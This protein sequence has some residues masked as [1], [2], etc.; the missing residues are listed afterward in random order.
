VKSL[1]ISIKELVSRY[2]HVNWALADQAMVSGVN[3]LTGIF[4]A[5]YLG[6]EEYGYFTLAWMVVQFCNSFQHAGIIAP[7]M[8]LGP[9]QK[10]EVS[11]KFYGA[12][13]FQQLVW[14]TICAILIVCVGALCGLIAPDLHVRILSIPL[15]GVLFL[16]Q[17][18]DF[19]R[20]YFFAINKGYLAFFNDSISYIGQIIVLA[21]VGFWVDIDAYNG[22]LIIGVTSLIAVIIGTFSLNVE[23]VRFSY[24]AESVVENHKY[25]RWLIYS[26]FMQYM[27]ANFFYMVSGALLGATSVGVIK[28]S[29]NIV[30]ILN[31]L[32]Q[33]MENFV[34]SRA[35]MKYLESGYG[36]VKSYVRRICL[37]GGAVIFI[38]SLFIIIFSKPIMTFVYGEVISE[39][40]YVLKILVISAFFSF[41]AFP[42]SSGLRAL[43]RTRD[44]FKIQVIAFIVSLISVYPLLY[45][46]GLTGA[47][48]R[49]VFVKIVVLVFMIKI[50]FNDK[51]L[52]G[53][54]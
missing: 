34:P 6:L 15:A 23:V 24:F 18:Q 8:S 7:M 12:M 32:F 54:I 36:G 28:S 53:E 51:L 22:L 31:I 29:Q 21:G 16:W 41:F 44:I 33:A 39:Y 11:G 49:G 25:S 19:Y 4:F 43:N 20:R 46:F 10:V 52:G 40:S 9:K 47:V 13:F 37:R 42:I 14:S 35:A 2:S 48:L 5:R 3:F 17:L 1:A 26:N 27:S 30:G 38:V 50:F 45:F